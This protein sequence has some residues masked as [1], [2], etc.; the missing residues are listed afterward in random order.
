MYKDPFFQIRAHSQVLGAQ[1]WIYLGYGERGTD[2][3]LITVFIWEVKHVLGFHFKTFLWL[4]ICV[5]GLQKK[6]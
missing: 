1:M 2:T 6:G 3:M 4:V 5:S